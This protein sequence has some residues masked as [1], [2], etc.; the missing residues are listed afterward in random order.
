MSGH[1]S[2]DAD[3]QPDDEQ[4]RGTT[5]ALI[6]IAPSSK[7]SYPR[8]Q[9]IP[10]VR[11]VSC[12]RNQ[13]AKKAP[14]PPHH[15]A[16][17]ADA[18]P[19]HRRQRRACDGHGRTLRRRHP[20]DSHECVEAWRRCSSS[21]PPCCLA[22]AAGGWWLQRVAFDT[23]PAAATLADV[24]LRGRRHPQPRSPRSPPTRTA[25]HARRPGRRRAGPGRPAAP[26]PPPGAEL[27]RADRRR[28][29]RPA[30]RRSATGPVQITGAA[31]RRS[32]CATERVGGLP[33]VILPVEEV[34]VLEHD[35]HVARLGRADRRH[36]RRR[37]P[38][39][40]A[41][42]PTR[43]RPTPCSASACSASSPASPSCC[44]AT[45]CRCSSSRRSTTTTWAAVIPAVAERRR[46]RSCSPRRS[47]C[48]PAGWR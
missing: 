40:R 30:D 6:A 35:P 9:P 38:A 32:S 5:T 2:D 31:A 16:A 25:A 27:M 11:H 47:C 36:R 18:A 23:G 24:V 26:R 41:C 14:R 13:P 8:R 12:L 4:R 1:V 39:A 15:G 7:P 20:R 22:L 29:P 10:H 28:L 46:C 33:P 45:S 21:S 17:P 19:Q 44:S 43:A 48:A 34:A 3:R 42:S 37:R